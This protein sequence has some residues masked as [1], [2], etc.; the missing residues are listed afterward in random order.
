MAILHRFFS[1]SDCSDRKLHQIV[2]CETDADLPTTG[3]QVG[4]FAI[5]VTPFIFCIVFSVGPVTWR[6]MLLVPI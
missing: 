3:V 1:P 5:V 2:F 6:R 4:D